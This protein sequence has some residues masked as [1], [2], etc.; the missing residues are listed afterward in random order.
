M[1]AP[2]GRFKL[3]GG[4]RAVFFAWLRQRKLMVATPNFSSFDN[5]DRPQLRLGCFK[6]ARGADLG[7][8]SGFSEI[9]TPEGQENFGFPALFLAWWAFFNQFLIFVPLF[10]QKQGYKTDKFFKKRPRAYFTPRN[11]LRIRHMKGTKF[12]KLRKNAQWPKYLA[13]M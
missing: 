1:W 10:Y 9:C 5:L 11:S 2:F 12:P 6:L 7:V 13:A 4:T 3:A 8:L